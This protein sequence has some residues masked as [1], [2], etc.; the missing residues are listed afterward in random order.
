[1]GLAHGTPAFAFDLHC[2]TSALSSYVLN[3]P[4]S[5]R[6]YGY[7]A[8]RGDN[9]EGYSGLRRNTAE[10]VAL[11]GASWDTRTRIPLLGSCASVS[12]AVNTVVPT[13]SAYSQQWV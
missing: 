3:T 9:G 11:S 5:G 1:M 7:C 10:H 4:A 13:S 2:T 6:G 8:P 12:T